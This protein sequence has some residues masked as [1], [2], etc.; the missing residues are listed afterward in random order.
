M[1]PKPVVSMQVS[2]ISGHLPAEIPNR[3]NP[4]F[5][6]DGTASYGVV[7]GDSDSIELYLN[8]LVTSSSSPPVRITEPII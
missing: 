7:F 6:Q 1:H 3:L 8:C 2:L 5:S 4:A